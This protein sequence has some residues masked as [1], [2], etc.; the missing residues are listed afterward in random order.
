MSGLPYVRH[1]DNQM[2]AVLNSMRLAM[3]PSDSEESF[4]QD[5]IRAFS[6]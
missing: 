4:D 3:T 2:T 5:P 1:P 6:S